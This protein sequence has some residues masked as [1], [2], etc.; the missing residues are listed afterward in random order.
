MSNLTC[1]F[2]YLFEVLYLCLYFFGKCKF[3]IA[4]P[5]VFLL[6]VCVAPSVNNKYLI[7]NRPEVEVI[8]S[9]TERI[10]P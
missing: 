9:P 10:A 3:D 7:N 4:C 8:I 5:P 1:V 6:F 2:T